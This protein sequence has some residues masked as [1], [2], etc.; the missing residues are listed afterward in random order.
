MLVNASSLVT[1]DAFHEKKAK[2][3]EVRAFMDSDRGYLSSSNSVKIRNSLANVI[4]KSVRTSAKLNCPY[5]C[6]QGKRP[7]MPPLIQGEE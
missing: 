6:P 5:S 7:G 3:R 1:N 2:S 4:V